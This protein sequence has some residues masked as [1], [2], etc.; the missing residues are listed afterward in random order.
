MSFKETTDAAR[1]LRNATRRLPVWS[2]PRLWSL[3]WATVAMAQRCP[4]C[5]DLP[6]ADHAGEVVIDDDGTPVQIMHNG[7]RVLADGYCGAWTTELIAACEGH[8]EPQEERV[9]YDILQRLGPDATMIELGAWWSYTR[10]VPQGGCTHAAALEPT[11]APSWARPT[12][13][14][15][16]PPA[17][18]LR[19]RRR[20]VPAG[21]SARSA[22]RSRPA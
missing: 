1:L 20:P 18:R 5:D 9:V 19:L 17:L 12:P 21:R 22:R 16:A 3:G 7:L 2:V 6:K 4:D 10:V 11:R 14:A 15:T 13:C 8:H